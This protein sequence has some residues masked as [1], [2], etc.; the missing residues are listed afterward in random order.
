LL[1]KCCDAGLQERTLS[2]FHLLIFP[3]N[4]GCLREET[5]DTI[6]ACTVKLL[7]HEKTKEE[8]MTVCV[9]GSQ[10]RLLNILM[11]YNLMGQN[12]ILTSPALEI[13]GNTMKG[14]T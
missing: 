1:V 8:I 14:L 11:N 13:L 2:C 7:I 3:H 12:K 4:I 6:L 5:K 10:C 9:T